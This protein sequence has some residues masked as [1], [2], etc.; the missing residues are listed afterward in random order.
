MLADIGIL[1]ALVERAGTGV[2]RYLDLS[3]LDGMVSLLSYMANG[4][5]LTGNPPPRVGSMHANIVPYGTY[6]AADG[7]FVVATFSAGYWPKLCDV[8]GIPEL[9]DDPR[10]ATNVDR[11]ARRQEVEA[12]VADR[13]AT[14]T[15]AHWDRVFTEAGIPSAP[16]RS[17]PEVVNDP[18]VLSRG[19]VPEF[20]H[21]R[22]GPLRIV[23]SPFTFA[24]SA[25]PDPVAAPLLGQHTRDIL[26]NELGLAPTEVTALA[27]AG[28]VAEAQAPTATAATGAGTNDNGGEHG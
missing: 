18:Q 17:V 25:K 26:E 9:A 22:L 11:L 7:D 16:I 10:Y 2:G 24:E 15:V 12:L 5:F 27:D 8:L 19:M 14:Q 28:V 6:P 13:L 21:P 23:G 3:M 1:A 4:L 20:D